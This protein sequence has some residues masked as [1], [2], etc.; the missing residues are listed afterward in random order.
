M[1]VLKMS[2]VCIID[3]LAFFDSSILPANYLVLLHSLAGFL[4]LYFILTPTLWGSTGQPKATQWVS[5]LSEDLNLCPHPRT[6]HKFYTILVNPARTVPDTYGFKNTFW[7]LHMPHELPAE[8]PV[9]TVFW[10]PKAAF[11]SESVSISFQLRFHEKV[12]LDALSKS[13]YPA[14]CCHLLVH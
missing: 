5:W 12:L 9:F 8:T 4:H 1:N 11:L 6:L 13:N 14:V 10:I 3:A 2:S 7:A